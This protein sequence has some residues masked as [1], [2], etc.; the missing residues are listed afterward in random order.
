MATILL[1]SRFKARREALALRER[2]ARRQMQE[3]CPDGWS[4]LW[5]VTETI[6]KT[7]TI[8]RTD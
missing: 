4:G 2:D 3:L 7:Y 8:V 5:E 6:R 1:L